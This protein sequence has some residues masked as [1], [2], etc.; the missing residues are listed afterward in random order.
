MFSVKVTDHIMIAHSL[1]DPF[2]GAAQNMHGATYV[3]EVTFMSEK[4]NSKNVVIDIGEASLI[5]KNVL[6]ELAYKNL[7]ELPQFK[8]ILTTTEYLAQYIHGEIKKKINNN[9]KLKVELLES[10][11]ASASYE[12]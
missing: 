4:L 11:V 9:L 1:P 10:H 2:F 7:D 6:S 5:T 3:T 8:G 12:S